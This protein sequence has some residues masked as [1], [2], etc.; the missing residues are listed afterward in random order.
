MFINGKSQGRLKHQEVSMD[1]YVNAVV[2]ERSPW[3]EL[4]TFSDPD[5]PAGKNRLDRYRLRW[6]DTVYEPGEIK[7]VA[8][9]AEGNVAAEKV[10]RTA[11]KPHHIELEA[12]RST[13]DATPLAS[14]GSAMDTPDLAFVTVRVVDK[15]GNL[16]PDAANQLSF[17]VGG[18]AVR[19]NSACNGDATSLEVF[20]KPT[21]KAFHG[22]LVVVLE[23][24]DLPGNASLTVT[25]KGLK[26]S[27]I[28]L[29]VR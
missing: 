28:A 11:G 17:T 18:T 2:K 4:C 10:V 8:Y 26:A 3:G 25:G 7:V 14:D 27:T 5:A 16:C 23:A 15:D 6:L 20:T 29:N 21:M 24:G 9:D 12:D 22:E 13:L 1:D 19:F